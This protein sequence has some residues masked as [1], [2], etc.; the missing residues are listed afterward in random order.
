M[1]EID[2]HF[3]IVGRLGYA[4][5]QRLDYLDAALT[6]HDRMLSGLMNNIR[7]KGLTE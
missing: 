3:E 6:E 7:S 1:S 4:S 5:S 2:T